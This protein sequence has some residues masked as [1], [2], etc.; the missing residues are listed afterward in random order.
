MAPPCPVGDTGRIRG[1]WKREKYST[2]VI[3]RLV[4]RGERDSGQR[5]QSR[6]SVAVAVWQCLIIPVCPAHRR[7]D[8]TGDDP[9]RAAA[10]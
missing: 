9:S 6:R 3:S 7:H 5:R 2:E 10:V 8:V 4:R 1:V